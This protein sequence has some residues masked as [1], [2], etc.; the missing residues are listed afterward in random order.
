MALTDRQKFGKCCGIFCSFLACLNIWFFLG[1]TIFQGMNNP[2]MKIE[3]EGFDNAGDESSNW[4]TAFIYVLAV[5]SQCNSVNLMSR[6]TFYVWRAASSALQ[7][8]VTGIKMSSCTTTRTEAK[9]SLARSKRVASTWVSKTR[10]KTQKDCHIKHLGKSC[11]L[12]ISSSPTY[13]HLI[14]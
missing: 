8:A 10:A 11:I 3:L 14:F 12:T 7:W 4:L 6:W 5:S 1:M 9:T 2:F 13:R